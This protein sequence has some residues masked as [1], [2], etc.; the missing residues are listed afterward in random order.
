MAG[1]DVLFRLSRIIGG[2]G[3]ELPTIAPPGFGLYFVESGHLEQVSAGPD[4]ED[5][6]DWPTGRNGLLPA[7]EGVEQSLVVVG[8]EAPRYWSS[9]RSPA[10]VLVLVLG[11]GAG[12]LGRLHRR[13]PRHRRRRWDDT[14]SRT[15]RVA[16]SRRLGC[17]RLAA[18]TTRHNPS[19]HGDPGFARAG[20]V[21]TRAKSLVAG[22]CDLRPSDHGRLDRPG[23]WPASAQSKWDVMQLLRMSLVG[24]RHPDAR[25]CP[26]VGG[27]HTGRSSSGFL[28]MTV[29]GMAKGRAATRRH[30]CLMAASLSPEADGLT[31]SSSTQPPRRSK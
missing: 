17:L 4:W 31:A 22:P 8:D 26:R 18:T 29:D 11:V 23:H 1:T 2:P 16:P 12:E 3:A 27:G 7:W 9:R 10:I 15:R 5:V 28:V 19:I 6:Y 14:T 25:R 30:Y 24:G 20:T 21:D 13:H